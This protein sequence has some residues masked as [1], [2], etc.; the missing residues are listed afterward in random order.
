MRL[1]LPPNPTDEQLEAAYAAGML[2]KEQLEDG[3]YYRGSCRN[4]Q[5]AR[6]HAG[7]QTFVHWRTKF[8]SR[9]LE[10]I[11]HPVDEKRYDVFLAQERV[12][13]GDQVIPDEQFARAAGVL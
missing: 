9:F 2:R 5:V 1:R 6:W 3:A 10:C 12:E 4:A 7:A 11:K 13:P 8:T